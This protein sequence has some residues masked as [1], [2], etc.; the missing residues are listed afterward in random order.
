MQYPSGNGSRCEAIR[1]KER[2]AILA[3]EI[4]KE[5]P[6]QASLYIECLDD[7]PPGAQV[8]LYCRVST[9]G[10][11]L[12]AQLA[13]C[14]KSLKEKGMRLI[15]K[16]FLETA[17][18]YDLSRPLFRKA[19]KYAR[20]NK[21]VLVARSIGR[22]LRSPFLSR[23]YPF[24]LPTE[25]QFKELMG[26]TKGVRMAT[27]IYPDISTEEERKIE[28][29]KPDKGKGGRGVKKR[30]RKGGRW[31][32]K[33]KLLPFVMAERN[34]GETYRGI[35]EKIA[36]EFDHSLSEMTICR[37]CREAGIN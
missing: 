11:S 36:A 28:S 29:E 26:I 15:G 22:I 20:K 24:A 14:L 19:I 1:R 6:A 13:Y 16:P 9:L 17:K 21:S 34:N 25:D 7:L 33:R 12:A 27:I 32:W 3:A 10:Q 8:V 37:W 18:G 35:S 5:E 4:K 30:K 23:K 31:R 2:L